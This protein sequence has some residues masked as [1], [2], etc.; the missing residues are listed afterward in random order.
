MLRNFAGHFKTTHVLTEQ[1]LSFIG[2]S[3]EGDR[4]DIERE[5]ELMKYRCCFTGHRP[6]KLNISEEAMI[7]KLRIAVYAAI[8]SGYRTFITGMAPGVDIWGANM[9]F[10]FKKTFPDLKLIAAVPYPK[11]GKTRDYKRN[12]AYK[13][14]LER[15]DYVKIISPNFYDG[16]FQKRNVWMVNHSSLVIAVCHKENDEIIDGGTKNTIEYAKKCNKD[17]KYIEV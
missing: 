4:M 11:F 3:V 10:E 2:F 5:K 8:K 17:I 6:E 12:L 16:V 13:R 15:A 7:G 14:V 1:E 9:V